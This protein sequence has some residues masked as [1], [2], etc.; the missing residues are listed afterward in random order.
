M[1][2]NFGWSQI[3][4]GSNLTFFGP[5]LLA[6]NVRWSTVPEQ[7]DSI[8]SIANV[9]LNFIYYIPDKNSEFAMKVY[10]SGITDDANSSFSNLNI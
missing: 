7:I 9:F 2:A 3:F 10:R 5:E 4:C 6:T 1:T 8:D